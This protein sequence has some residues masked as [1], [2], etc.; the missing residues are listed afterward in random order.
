[1]SDRI[2]YLDGT[3]GISGDMTVAALLDLGADRVKL[4][5]A[6]A[7]LGIGGFDIAVSRKLSHGLTG[8]DFDVILHAHGHDHAHEHEHEH[9]HGHAHRHLA[10]VE[11]II[12]R[13]ALSDRARNL[14]KRIFRVVAEAEAQAHGC[15]LEAVH[16]HEVGAIDS[17]VDIV[18]AAVC[19]DDLGITECVVTGFSEGMGF[20]RCQHG[21]LPVPVPAVLNIAVS[22]AIALRPTDVRGEMVTPTGIAIAAALRTRGALP[23]EYRVQKVG[24]GLGKRDFGRPNFLRAMLLSEAT[25]SGADRVWVLE[26]NIDDSTGEELGLVLDKLLKA[27]ARD[28]HLLPCVMKKNRPGWLLRALADAELIP[29][30]ERILFRD[31][32]TIGARRFPVE[33]TCMEREQTRVQLPFGEVR[34]KKCSFGELVRYYPEFESVRA[35]AETTSLSFREVYRQAQAAAE[36]MGSPSK[37]E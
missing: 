2:L 22:H 34:V 6:L 31:T 14:A 32:T 27:G 5:A 28:A 30:L 24:L 36:V 3:C 8:L 33:R 29:T 15:A 18:S 20:V 23:A 26:T 35:I 13:G 25:G 7:S 17:I 19:I 9:E 16:F 21:E 11:A 37:D 4:D 12:D 10:D 1:M